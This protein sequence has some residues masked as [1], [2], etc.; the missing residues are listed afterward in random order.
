MFSS[1]LPVSSYVNEVCARLSEDMT[2]SL[3]S[4]FPNFNTKP[5]RAHTHSL[6]ATLQG[7]IH[8][9]SLARRR[10]PASFHVKSSYSRAG[11]RICFQNED[12]GI[13]CRKYTLHVYSK[14]HT[15]AKELYCVHVFSILTRKYALSFQRHSSSTRVVDTCLAFV[16][17]LVEGRRKPA[18]Q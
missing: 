18:T 4:Q 5:T 2:S 11:P 3:E 13:V 7:S 8:S 12:T 10:L 16:P 15:S 14:P 1:T 17:A 9:V 6:R